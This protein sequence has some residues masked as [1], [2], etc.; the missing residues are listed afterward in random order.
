MTSNER[1]L[2][3]A[4]RVGGVPA[5]TDD[6]PTSFKRAAVGRLHIVDGP[7]SGH[8][9]IIYDGTQSI[10]RDCRNGLALTFGD[11]AVHRRDHAF[12]VH[13]AGRVRLIENGKSNP[14]S[15]NGSVILGSTDLKNGDL[16]KLG[17]TTLRYGS[18]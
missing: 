15:L 4:G 13:E 3:T 1:T 17:H 12:I 10:G 7:G 5:N 18:E 16:L 6:M 14:V 8:T 2:V 9:L 11:A